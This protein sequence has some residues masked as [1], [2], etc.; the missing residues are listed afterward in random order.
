MIYFLAFVISFLFIIYIWNSIIDTPGRVTLTIL[1]VL[2]CFFVGFIING[3]FL[4]AII[5]PTDIG[6]TE[7]PVYT[8]PITNQ[9]YLINSKGELIDTDNYE[10]SSKVNKPVGIEK[11]VKYDMG[12]W[13]ISTTDTKY[14]IL[15]P[16]ERE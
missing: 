13:G 5:S 8:N 16:L 6:E 3:V 12:I 14:R 4:A 9:Y 10:I 1:I 7:V 11:E 2:L 15:I